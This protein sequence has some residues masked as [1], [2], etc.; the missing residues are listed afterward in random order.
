M[1]KYLNI[2]KLFLNKLYQLKYIL[3]YLNLN[4]I[5]S[6]TSEKFI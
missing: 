4:N 3:Y 6:T 5:G 1:N 2:K